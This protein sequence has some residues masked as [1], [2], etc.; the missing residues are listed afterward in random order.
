VTNE[1][2]QGRGGVLKAKIFKGMYEPRLE[3]PEGCGVQTKKTLHGGSM[4]IFWNNMLEF[5]G[6]K[7]WPQL[8]LPITNIA[9]Y[10]PPPHGYYS[11]FG[12]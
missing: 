1:H 5:W 7:I 12:F 10:P 8:Y 6:I 9:K 11:S 4:D 2:K 3:F